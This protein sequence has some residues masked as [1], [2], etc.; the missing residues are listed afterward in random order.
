MG[1]GSSS[2]FRFGQVWASDIFICFH[3]CGSLRLTTRPRGGEISQRAAQPGSIPE[4][5]RAQFCSSSEAWTVRSLPLVSRHWAPSL[6]LCQKLGLRRC[7]LVDAL[8]QRLRGSVAGQVGDGKCSGIC[9]SSSPCPD[10][11]NG[12]CLDAGSFLPAS[13]PN[14][15]LPPASF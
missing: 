11:L 5:S 4:S 8:C 13:S 14:H 1:S 6:L 7:G 12:K 3:S 9:H 15:T 10:C 2:T